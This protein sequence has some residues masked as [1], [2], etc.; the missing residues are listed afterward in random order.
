MRIEVENNGRNER[1]EE[2]N[3]ERK[4]KGGIVSST[5]AL[6]PTNRKEYTQ[7]VTAHF[8][9][10]VVRALVRAIKLLQNQGVGGSYSPP[11]HATDV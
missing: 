1:K 4:G 2:I 6:T 5:K 11:K 10:N 7:G 9:Q 8:E 3:K